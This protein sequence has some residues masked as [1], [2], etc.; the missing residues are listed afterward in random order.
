PSQSPYALPIVVACK[1]STQRQL[2]KVKCL[3]LVVSA[4]GI[5]TDPEKIQK[6]PTNWK[7]VS[8]FWGFTGYYCQFMKNYF[9]V[10]ALL[11]CLT[12]GSPK[13]GKG[14]RKKVA[15]PLPFLWIDE[16]SQ[17][18]STIKS[19]LITAPVLGY[20]DYS[21]PF[22][23]QTDASIEGLGA[24]LAQVQSGVE[25][26]IAYASRGLSHTEKRYPAHKLEFLALKWAVADKF[27]DYLLECHFTVLMDNNPLVYVKSTTQL[28]AT[29]Q[30]WIAKLAEFD[31]EVK[32]H[33]GRNNTSADGLSRMPMD[34]ATQRRVKEASGKGP[35]HHL[36]S[37]LLEGTHKKRQEDPLVCCLL[38]QWDKLSMEDVILYNTIRNSEG[39]VVKQM[40]LP[41]C[42]QKEAFLLLHTDMGHMGV[43]RTVELI[44]AQF[45]W[46]NMYSIIKGWCD[47]CER[48]LHKVPAPHTIAT[49]TSIHTVR[50]LELV[51]LDFL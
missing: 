46:A 20:S 5:A 4:N 40:V 41:D 51:C 10:A 47:T 23:L 21:L 48:C 9:K 8:Q 16:C 17:A 43:D 45:Y 14:M 3:G 12:A 34:E 36:G 18:F 6:T 37:A 44:Q 1:N 7:E 31:F 26:V 25:R 27:Q 22:I 50:P 30:R 32:Y 2:E 13:R 29:S 19:K 35:S 24:V 15:K 39:E 28:D 11:F 42:L 33:P 38:R 49:L